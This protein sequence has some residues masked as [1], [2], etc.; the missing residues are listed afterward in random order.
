MAVHFR[1]AGCRTEPHAKRVTAWAEE[2][3]LDV[4]P[5]RKVIEVRVRGGGK[6]AAL[7]ALALR[8]AANHLLYAG[9]DTTDLPALAFAALHG[10]AIFVESDERDVPDIAGLW[11]AATIEDL[12]YG[13][14][15]ELIDVLP[16]VVP[17]LVS[18]GD[19]A[20]AKHGA[21]DSPIIGTRTVM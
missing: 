5:G 13:F 17:S 7:R 9:D 10:R 14:A 20:G 11:R 2:H 18:R 21:I 19:R 6:R 16:S 15:R 4:M 1:G 3:N 8:L 12:C